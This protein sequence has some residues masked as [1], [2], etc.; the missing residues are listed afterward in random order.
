MNYQRLY[1]VL[2]SRAIARDGHPFRPW[3]CKVNFEIHH[4]KPTCLF[5]NGKEN[6]LANVPE[7]LVWLTLDEHFVAHRLLAKIHGGKLAVAFM[8]MCNRLR[9]N[10]KL[11][12]RAKKEGLT[13]R[14]ADPD[15]QARNQAA[16]KIRWNDEGKR[17][18]QAE[19][20]RQNVRTPEWKKSLQMAINRR[21]ADPEWQEKHKNWLQA[22]HA[23]P[24]HKQNLRQTM[25][26]RNTDPEYQA[27]CKAGL[28]A[29]RNTP[30]FKAR[31]MVGGQKRKESPN[32]RKNHGAAMSRLH[33]D[34]SYRATMK[35]A[36]ERRTEDPAWLE[37]NRAAVERRLKTVIGVCIETGEKVTYRGKQEIIAAGFCHKQVSACCKGKNKSHKGYRWSYQ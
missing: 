32:W 5:D 12:A 14:N 20:L 9:S 11:Y 16:Q 4:I 2:I 27:K 37:A 29:I 30:E 25:L 18:K 7:N 21:T 28:D 6:P 8:F 31:L 3:N 22:L 24:E 15:W 34:P 36:I 1:D 26:A 23:D 10:N 19:I 33:A 13:A 35:A 17:Q